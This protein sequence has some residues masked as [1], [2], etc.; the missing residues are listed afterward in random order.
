M[1]VNSQLI[2]VQRLSVCGCPA[3]NDIYKEHPRSS[4]TIVQEGAERQEEPEVGERCLFDMTHTAAMAAH[5]RPAKNQ[6]SKHSSMEQEEVQV[7]PPLTEEV[8]RVAGFWGKS[9]LSFQDPVG[10]QWMTLSL[11]TSS[12]TSEYMSNS[13]CGFL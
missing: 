5:T 12:G 9:Q 4:G 1:V 11:P 6:A 10:L 2:K 7:R 8:L 3:T 13:L